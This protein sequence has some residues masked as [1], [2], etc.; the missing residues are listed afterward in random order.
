MNNSN[1][2]FMNMNNSNNMMN[3]NNSLNYNPISGID[4]PSTSSTLYSSL[5]N[6]PSN[7]LN[8]NLL[9]STLSATAMP[10]H[11]NAESITKLLLLLKSNRGSF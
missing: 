9:N 4:S 7:L 3:M 10:E 6:S 5:N 2:L 8:L 1:N 11:L